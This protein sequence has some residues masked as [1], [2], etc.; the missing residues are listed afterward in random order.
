MPGVAHGSP[1]PVTDVVLSGIK[2]N[3]MLKI[4][5]VRPE[6]LTL[7]SS[8]F[9][10]LCCNFVL[11]QHLFAI[12]SS[13]GQGLLMRLAFGLIVLA[14]FNLVLTLL[15]FRWLLKPVLTVLLLISAGVAYFMSQY[16]V[17]IDLGMLRNAAETDVAEVRDLLSIKLALYVL[18]LGVLPAFLVWRTPVD[19]RVWSRELLSK[20]IV[21][22]ACVAVLGGVALV[23]YQ[24][25][26]SLFRNHH[27]LRLMVVPS[28]YLGASLSYLREQIS[29]SQQPF[30]QVAADA[31][32]APVWQA[33]QRKSLTVLVI[34]E[35]AR[36]ENFGVLGYPR[37]TTPQLQAESGLIAYT[38]VRSCGTETAVSVPCMFSNLGRSDYNASKARSQ[39]GLLD[40]LQ[41]AGFHVLWRDNQS[42]C[43]GTCD[44]VAFEDVS[45]RQDPRLCAKASAMTR[46]C[47]KICKASSTSW[48]RT[49]CWCC[50]RW[51]AMART[52]SSAIRKSSSSSA[53]SAIAMP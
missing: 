15:A 17:L 48:I 45:N 20:V 43:K 34:G 51:V 53:R 33:H 4:K 19:Y 1:Y 47:C 38:N 28:N 8:A 6:V 41:R 22:G 2:Q 18:L 49:L 29:S 44:R 7:L 27:E 9:L 50:I 11:W 30:R 10:L 37:N 40:I 42:G 21:G 26:A 25:L 16:G 24:G 52:I 31:V 14:I 3:A 36:A 35:S 5:S 12:T 39:E 13:D 46:F 32:K 23:N